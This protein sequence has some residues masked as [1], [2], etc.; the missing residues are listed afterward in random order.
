MSPAD[1][2]RLRVVSSAPPSDAS[3]LEGQSWCPARISRTDLHQL[4]DGDRPT[5]CAAHGSLLR[6]GPLS[7]TSARA[8]R[9]TSQSSVSVD[10][11]YI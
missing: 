10:A 9:D 3:V 7:L 5:S 6:S 11:P 1:E 2:P 4:G 8:H